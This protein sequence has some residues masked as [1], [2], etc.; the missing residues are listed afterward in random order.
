MFVNVDSSRLLPCVL[1]LIVISSILLVESV[2]IVCI[3][4]DSLSAIGQQ[5]WVCRFKWVIKLNV[6]QVLAVFDM[7]YDVNV[8][9]LL[10]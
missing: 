7:L 9:L 1:E 4:I 5:L 8:S 3:Y 10:T 2:V 6:K